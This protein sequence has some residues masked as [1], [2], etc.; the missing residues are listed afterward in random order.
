MN[1]KNLNKY[2]YTTFIFVIFLNNGYGEAFSAKVVNNSF[3]K[4]KMILVE[5]GVFPN[6]SSDS[7]EKN[8]EEFTHD[9]LLGRWYKKNKNLVK[10]LKEESKS[11]FEGEKVKSFM[12]ADIETTWGEWK[13][14]RDWALENGYKYLEKAGVGSADDHPV[15]LYHF[16]AIIW[17]NA[18]SE[19]EG[20]EPVYKLNG[21][22]YKKGPDRVWKI[23]PTATNLRTRYPEIDKKA[24][25]YRLPTEAEWEWAARGG[26]NS[27]GY[28]FSGSNIATEVAWHICNTENTIEPLGYSECEPGK[29]VPFGTM[30]VAQ[31]KANELGLYDMS[32]N[33]WEYCGVGRGRGSGYNSRTLPFTRSKAGYPPY[34]GKKEPANYKY[35]LVPDAGWD[36]SSEELLPSGFRVARNYEKK[37]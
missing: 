19:M 15:R 27:R 11:I 34:M 1:L 28:L 30:P 18:K 25:G 37:I 21:R 7:F 35:D 32:G 23:Q 2:F 4:A 3:P 22:V 24:N 13:V 6:W 5:G 31:K 17:C 8:L 36:Y 29:L 20:L 26:I 12:I 33:A 16:D 10:K 9:P 14:V